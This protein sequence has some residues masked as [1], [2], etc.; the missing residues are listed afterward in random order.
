MYLDK[1][2]SFKAISTKT[3]IPKTTVENWAK[4]YNLSRLPIKR[5]GYHHTKETIDKIRL[6][7]KGRVPWSKGQKFSMEYCQKISEATLKFR[8]DKRTLEDFYWNIGLT[9]A[10]IGEIYMVST[11][12]VLNR[13]KKFGILRCS[14]RTAM[15]GKCHTIETKRKIGDAQR[16]RKG[17]PWNI[18]RIMEYSKMLKKRW[19]N[20]DYKEE[21]LR[22]MREAAKVKPTKLELEFDTLCKEH[23][24]PFMYVG[25]GRFFIHGFN[26]DFIHSEGQQI[27]LEL[28]GDYWHNPE[29]RKNIP[30][31]MLEPNRKAIFKKYGWRLIVIWE[32]ELKE[33]KSSPNNILNK[34][35]E[36]MNQ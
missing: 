10:Q 24:I 14:H 35:K 9:L 29:K 5:N 15:I 23:Q 8:V 20:P 13:M 21:H 32:H 12:T 33:L 36:L 25:D 2:L 17:I 27:A 1:K 3:G 6:A 22:V 34:I 18:T 26:P 31:S 28:F 7:T 11:Q 30:S 4:K 16:G 19:A